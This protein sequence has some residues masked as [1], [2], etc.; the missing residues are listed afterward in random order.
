[1]T[2]ITETK[3]MTQA[4]YDALPVFTREELHQYLH[5][6]PNTALVIALPPELDTEGGAAW[7]N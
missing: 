1:M 6:H 2:P 4:D 3:T 7:R 5:D